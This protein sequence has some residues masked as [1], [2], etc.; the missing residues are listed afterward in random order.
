MC[1][2]LLGLT[3]KVEGTQDKKYIEVY[4]NYGDTVWDIAKDFR[5]KNKDIRNLIYEIENI[6]SL[7]DYNIYPGQIIKIPIK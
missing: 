2:L 6:N 1:Q 4:V 3:N 5:D 7:K